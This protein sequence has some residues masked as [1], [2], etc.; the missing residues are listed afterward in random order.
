MAPFATKQHPDGTVERINKGTITRLE[1]WLISDSAP[2]EDAEELRSQIIRPLRRVRSERQ[3]AAHKIIKNEYDKRLTLLKRGILL[4]VAFA[5]GNIFF[6]LSK[7]ADSPTM[8]APRWF[9]EGRIEVF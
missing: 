1:E 7:R 9:E 8:R 5:L 3:P 6:I 4:D 2:K